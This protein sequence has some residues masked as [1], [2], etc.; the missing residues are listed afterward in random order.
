LL[1]AAVISCSNTQH[2]STVEL[3]ASGDHSVVWFGS[4]Y[5]WRELRSRRNN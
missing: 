4:V 5:A 3:G 2:R 1:A